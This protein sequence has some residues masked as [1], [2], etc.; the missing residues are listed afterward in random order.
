MHEEKR[1]FENNCIQALKAT[2]TAVLVRTIAAA[3]DGR[4]ATQVGVDLHVDELVPLGVP[5]HKVH[6]H[7][8][9][10]GDAHDLSS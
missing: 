4:H 10:L 9:V 8:C 3:A 5:V 2:G 6:L 1:K 7:A